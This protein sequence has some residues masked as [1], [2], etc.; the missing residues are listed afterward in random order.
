MHSKYSI[1]FFLFIQVISAQ[2]SVNTQYIYK[3]RE[4]N[5]LSSILSGSLSNNLVF[6]STILSID[7]NTASYTTTTGA[8]V[9]SYISLLASQTTESQSAS[10][11]S[12][13]ENHSSSQELSSTVSSTASSTSSVTTSVKEMSKN[14]GNIKNHQSNTLLVSLGIWIGFL[15]T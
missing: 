9:N 7:D 15:F 4:E 5:Y 13:S 12:T 10:T 8:I 3:K 14:S 1:I 2:F 6:D 11:S